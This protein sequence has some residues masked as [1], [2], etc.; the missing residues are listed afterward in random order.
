MKNL[1]THTLIVLML[2][3]VTAAVTA[4]DK[5]TA[6]RITILNTLGKPQ[7]GMVLKVTGYSKE[8]LSDSLGIVRFEQEVN[9]NYTRMVNFYFP[10]DRTR[11][12]KTLKLDEAL[13]DTLL[14]IDS[15]EDLAQ[16]KQ[17]GRL[18]QIEGLVRHGGTPLAG[19]E[20]QIQGTGRKATAD[21]LGRFCIEADYSHLIV[22]R[23]EGM[24]TRYLE[25]Q[26][27]LTH[28][29]SPYEIDMR[30]KGADRIYATA[31]QMPEYPGGMK[32]F[33][34][35]IERRLRPSR[36][37]EETGTEGV[38]VIQFVVEKDGRITSP[39]IVRPLQAS[40]DTAALKIIQTMPRWTAGKEKGVSVR[41]KY[42]VPIRFK[43][44]APEPPMSPADSLRMTVQAQCADSISKLPPAAIRG[45]LTRRA[46]IP[47]PMFS[48]AEGIRLEYRKLPYVE[49]KEK[50][51][52]F[53]QRLFGR[54]D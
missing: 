16:A 24:E 5:R 42:S 17:S 21:A 37:A 19:A 2:S 30:A 34:N 52:G 53:F 28:T 36:L 25:I 23:A 43:K 8:H 10:T 46:E 32:A 13:A 44:P 35:Y 11:P 33:F 7:A 29:G 14:Y 31:E 26:P 15:P 49:L 41:C 27:F 4:Q 3:G 45:R 12:V 39:S 51:R 40:L 50:K 20:I 54:K 47:A 48:A 9:K 18:F 6:F 22:V 1:L 38:T